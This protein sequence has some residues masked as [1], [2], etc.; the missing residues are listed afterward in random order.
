[1]VNYYE[2]LGVTQNASTSE[3]KKAYNN[4]VKI[5]YPDKNTGNTEMFE[6]I[7]KA[8]K[9]LSDKKKREE[10]DMSLKKCDDF[11]NLKSNFKKDLKVNNNYINNTVMEKPIIDSA[12]PMDEFKNRL[13]DYDIIRNQDDIE[14]TPNNIFND[15]YENEVFNS[16]FESNYS[17]LNNKIIKIKDLGYFQNDESYSS[18]EHNDNSKLNDYFNNLNEVD[19]S[20]INISTVKNRNINEYKKI[21]S[22]ELND[23]FN[24]IKKDRKL[25]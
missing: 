5:Y 18:I 11:I 8:Y 9:K 16:V 17:K 19:I 15:K 3:I 4:L 14:N 7:V 21:P 13:L 6:L 10:Y 22:S 12:I 2:V 25:N 1:M 23:K 20:N 24:S